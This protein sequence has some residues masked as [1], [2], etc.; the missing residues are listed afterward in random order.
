MKA[1]KGM[2]SAR[3]LPVPQRQMRMS[4]IDASKPPKMPSMP[5]P[6]GMGKPKKGGY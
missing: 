6:K 4:M 5:K 2:K 1:P 3:P